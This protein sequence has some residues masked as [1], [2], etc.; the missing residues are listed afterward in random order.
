MPLRNNDCHIQ[1]DGEGMDAKIKSRNEVSKRHGEV[2]TSAFWTVYFNV[3]NTLQD[4]THLTFNPAYCNA[5][6]RIVYAVSLMTLLH[7]PSAVERLKQN[8]P[9]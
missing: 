5:E 9:H 4:K 8:R 2:E 7:L 6:A 3:P 1:M